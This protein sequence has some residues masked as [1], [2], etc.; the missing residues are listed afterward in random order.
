[1]ETPYVNTIDHEVDRCAYI[2]SLESMIAL[3]P[4]TDAPFSLHQ[5][6]QNIVDAGQVAFAFGAQPSE[7]L[8]IETDAHRSPCAVRQGVGRP[9]FCDSIPVSSY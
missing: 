6:A 5:V 9:H 1:M 8:W 3:S 7:H 4:R 2:Q